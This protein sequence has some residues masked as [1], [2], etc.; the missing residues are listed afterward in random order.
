MTSA[1]GGGF[2]MRTRVRTTSTSA[3]ARRST[4]ITVRSNSRTMAAPSRRSSRASSGPWPASIA[5][6]SRPR[7]SSANAALSSLVI[8]RAV[9]RVLGSD[10]CCGTSNGEHKGSLEARR[11]E[12]HSDR[13]RHSRSGPPGGGGNCPLDVP[14]I[15]RRRQE[16]KRRSQEHLNERGVQQT[17]GGLGRAAPSTRC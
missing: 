17:W 7:S 1:A 16:S 13:P 6:S 10:E 12:E 5:A 11:A 14:G 9:R 15:C 2:R 3:N 4:F 8:V